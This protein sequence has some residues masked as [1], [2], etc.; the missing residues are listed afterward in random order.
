MQ[1]I[2]S[3]ICESKRRLVVNDLPER[4]YALP[5]AYENLSKLKD[6]EEIIVFPGFF[7]YTK[8]GI[9]RTFDR[10]GSDITGSILASAVG[11]D[12]I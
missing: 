2:T 1:R 5:E 8:D 9:L 3:K 7:G 12:L 11:A 4:T 10:G 6:V